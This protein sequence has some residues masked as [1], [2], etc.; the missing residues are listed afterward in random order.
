MSEQIRQ[1]LI[2]AAHG[3]KNPERAAQGAERTKTDGL[4]RCPDCGITRYPRNWYSVFCY[5]G[6][7]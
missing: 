4:H 3:R 1:S 5:C 2:D 6:Y 7:E